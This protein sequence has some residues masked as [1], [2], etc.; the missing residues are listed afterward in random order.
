MAFSLLTEV[1]QLEKN[2]MDV[3]AALTTDR[4]GKPLPPQAA[5][6][7]KV[8]GILKEVREG[9]EKPDGPDSAIPLE[10]PEVEWGTAFNGSKPA[11]AP[12]TE[13]LSGSVSDDDW[14]WD[15]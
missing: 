8:H 7:A 2:V 4:Q 11:P 1:Q 9:L 14:N 13:D 5:K 3:L 10:K 15:G 12:S 6:L